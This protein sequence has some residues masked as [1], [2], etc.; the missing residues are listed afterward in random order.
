MSSS[1]FW[2]QIAMIPIDT[3]ASH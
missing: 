3:N 1:T 2:N